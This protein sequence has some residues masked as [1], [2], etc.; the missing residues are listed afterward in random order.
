MIDRARHERVR[1]ASAPT[2]ELLLDEAASTDDV[3]F[4]R[5][6]SAAARLLSS[7]IDL[8]FIAF[9]VVVPATLL[10]ILI[11][12]PVKGQKITAAQ[13]RTIT[14]IYFVVVIVVLLGYLLLER[15]TSGSPGRR[16]LHLRLVSTEG[17]RPSWGRLLRKYSVV[18]LVAVLPIMFV[19]V[20]VA[21]FFALIQPQRRNGLDLLAG[22]RVVLR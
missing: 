15:L 20:L 21:M 4:L 12:H 7:L 16:L 3:G 11:L 8:I 9:A 13:N 22:T 5:T 19:V 18:L 10:P 6:P 17:E 1:T 14:W 2:L